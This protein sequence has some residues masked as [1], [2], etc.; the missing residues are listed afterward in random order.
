MFLNFMIPAVAAGCLPNPCKNGGS[1]FSDG[2]NFHCFCEQNFH[3]D[4]CEGM[5]VQYKMY[6]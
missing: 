2:D 5:S 3:G 6:V 1:C 4:K